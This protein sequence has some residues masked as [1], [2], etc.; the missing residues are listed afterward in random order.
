MELVR[1]VELGALLKQRG[2]PGLPVDQSIEYVRHACEALQYVHDQQ[3]VHRDVK[4]QNLILAEEGVVLVDFGIARQ[5]DEVEIEGTA[6]IGTPRFMAP[7][8]IAGGHV[9]PRTD[10][11]IVAA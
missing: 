2:S 7:E 5:I 8:I 10:V 11:F 4:P 1:G 6:G 3:I 9:S